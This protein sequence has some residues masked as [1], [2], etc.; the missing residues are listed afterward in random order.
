[1]VRWTKV[2]TLVV[3]AAASVAILAGTASA[4]SITVAPTSAVPGGT[5]TVSGDVLAANDQLHGILL[6]A[7]RQA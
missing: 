7:L 1:M 2:T 4:A 6:S 5:V 3:G